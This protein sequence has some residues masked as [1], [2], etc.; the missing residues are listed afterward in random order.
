MKKNKDPDYIIIDEC[1][2]L[3]EKDFDNLGKIL[4][5]GTLSNAVTHAEPFSLNLKDI[6]DFQERMKVYDTVLEK[7]THNKCEAWFDQFKVAEDKPLI[8]SQFYGIPVAVDPEL[9]EGTIEIRNNRGHI[10]RFKIN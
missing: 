3:S 5:E 8:V 2:N 1:N 4:Q 9:P 6:V 10:R 7:I